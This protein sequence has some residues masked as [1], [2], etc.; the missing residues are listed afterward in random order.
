VVAWG[1]DGEPVDRYEKVRRV[2]FGEYIP[3]RSWV[4]RVADLSLIP[5]EA[6]VGDGPGHVDT[7]AGE[8]AVVISYELFFVDRARSGIEEGAT[9]L[10][11]PTNS[12]SYR[13]SLV[14][15]QAVAATRLRALETGR[16][17]L[18]AAPTGFSAVL[19]EDGRVRERTAQRE[20]AVIEASV[21]RRTGD[22][23]AVRIGRLPVI[24]V[25]AL[26]LGLAWVLRPRRGPSPDR[27]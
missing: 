2:P 16:W 9:V 6:L 23:I 10:L 26:M 11:A 17:T 15:S 1:P 24:G 4:D 8:L 25:A 5:R 3:L 20:Q 14:A 18:L 21:E 12:S 22:T 13:T 27:R 19:D 7:P